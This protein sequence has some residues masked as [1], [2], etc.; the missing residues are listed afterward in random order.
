MSLVKPPSLDA[1]L[2]VD[3]PDDVPDEEL[4]AP[5]ILRVRSKSTVSPACSAAAAST[6]SF[7]VNCLVTPKSCK[8]RSFSIVI[9]RMRRLDAKL[10]QRTRTVLSIDVALLRLLFILA[11]CLSTARGLVM[12]AASRPAFEPRRLALE[13][14]RSQLRLAEISLSPPRP[15]PIQSA[16]A[17][18]VQGL[19][20]AG[21]EVWRQVTS[22]RV[23]V[24]RAVL[25]QQYR[26]QYAL[27]EHPQS[28]RAAALAAPI[29][30]LSDGVCKAL[31]PD[32]HHAVCEWHS[33][34]RGAAE[35]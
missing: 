30:A 22:W 33:S 11:C 24:A 35:L 20:E 15:A 2:E 21:R 23:E 31:Y 7:S 32:S 1:M 19:S 13:T 6:P 27:A 17:A 18:L 16:A 5:P 34:N 26:T 25:S 10:Q 3:V 29:A 8:R 9:E 14:G 12:P 28:G 4:E